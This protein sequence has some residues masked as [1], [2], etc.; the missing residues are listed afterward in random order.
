[1]AR[2]GDTGPYHPSNVRKA[3]HG[4]NISEG[5]MGILK[6]P[7][8]EE[9]KQKLRDISHNCGNE[10]RLKLAKAS[11]EQMLAFARDGKI[12]RGSGGR[13]AKKKEN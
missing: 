10:T 2:T 9:T 12:K 4:E 7:M 13:F 8:S 3:T 5:H 1:M 6:G 11:R